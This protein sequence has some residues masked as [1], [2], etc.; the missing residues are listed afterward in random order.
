MKAFR[1]TK[2]HTLIRE[3]LNHDMTKDDILKLVDTHGLRASERAMTLS[4]WGMAIDRVQKKL[5]QPQGEK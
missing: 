4:Y 5:T 2:Q 3:A 1:W